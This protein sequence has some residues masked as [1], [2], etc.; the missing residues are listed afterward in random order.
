MDRFKGII[1][2][3]FTPFL[4]NEDVDEDS[5]VRLI[6][7]LI[8]AGVHAIWV[9][10]SSGEFSALTLDERKRLYELSVKK[11][12]GKIPVLAGVSHSSTR[13]AIDL[14]QSAEEAGADALIATP[15]YYHH[16][17]PASVFEHYKAIVESVDIPV[18]IYDNPETTMH[19]LSTDLVGRLVRELKMHTIKLCPYPHETPL[20]RAMKLKKLLGD[21]CNIFV[22]SAQ[23]AYYAFSMGVAEGVVSAMLNVIPHEFVRMYNAIQK[24][25]EEIARDIQYR[26]VLPLAFFAFYFS[27]EE[28]TYPQVG[29]T[30]LKWRGVI[31]H[32]QVRK[33][34]SPLPEWQV[35]YLKDMARYT[36]LVP[37]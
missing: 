20:E 9:E 26:K 25:D 31:S 32:D 30:I 4:P 5:F 27:K 29:K 18:A 24:G 34:L 6:Q 1:P 13:V 17:S 19:T 7:F 22:A 36:G 3:V 16:S 37:V 2:P 21:D 8:E 12:E 15:P 14:A 11:V 33:P 28:T 23:F 35:K 10:G